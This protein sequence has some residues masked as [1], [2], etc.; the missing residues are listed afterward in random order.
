MIFMQVDQ[1]LLRYAIRD[2]IPV[3]VSDFEHLRGLPGGREDIYCPECDGRVTVRLS[4]EHK[5]RDHFAHLPDSTCSLRDGGES[6]H[7]LNAKYYLASQLKQYRRASLIIKCAMCKND[8]NYLQIPEYDEVQVERKL[9]K[10]RPDISLMNSGAAVGAA[11][12]AYTSYV[13][14]QRRVDLNSYGVGWFEI[15]ALSVHPQY[16]RFVHDASVI[17]IDARG[18]R[19]SYP[20][21]PMY[22]D[23]CQRSIDKQRRESGNSLLSLDA[24]AKS[25]IDYAWHEGIDLDVDQYGPRLSVKLSP[26]LYIAVS[27]HRRAQYERMTK[28]TVEEE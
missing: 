17:G 15:P 9:K 2:S 19:I 3:H 22:C 28:K 23:L 13:D 24:P 5:K 7:H 25:L 18:A 11:E 27:N 4:P 21:P 14:F 1:V 20:R 6:A 8:Y 12:V 16:F 10:R 26:G